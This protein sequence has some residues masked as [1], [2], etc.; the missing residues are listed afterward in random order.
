MLVNAPTLIPRHASPRRVRRAEGVGSCGLRLGCSP[1]E[2]G[3]LGDNQANDCV[4]ILAT[5][6]GFNIALHN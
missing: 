2:L 3:E 5:L 1:Y 4:M 6:L